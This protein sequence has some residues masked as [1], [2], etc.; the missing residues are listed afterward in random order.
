LFAQADA[1]V[2]P[3]RGID[4]SEVAMSAITHGVPVL[5]GAIE[6]FRELFEEE[7][8][9]LRVPPTDAAALPKAIADWIRTPEQLCA[10]TDAMRLRRARI[11]SWG[12]IARRHLAVYAEA[13]DVWI[14]NR[15]QTARPSR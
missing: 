10:L 11:P 13:H 6:G 1:I 5:A 15:S 3:Y 12:E 2:L 7:G 4:A 14:A 9:A 8:G